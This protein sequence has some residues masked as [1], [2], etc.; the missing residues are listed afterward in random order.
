MA[1]RYVKD[2]EFPAAAGYTKSCETSPA[3]MAK[4]PMYAKGG[5]VAKPPAGKAPKGG[6]M[7]V[8]GVASP[9]KPPMKKAQGSYVDQDE[10]MKMLEERSPIQSG[11]YGKKKPAPP[12]KKEAPRDIEASDLYDEE[13][14]RRLER[15]YAKG[16]MTKS[17]KKIGKVMREYKAGELH[18]GKDG[19]VVKNPKQ[20]IAIA[21]SEA[22]KAKK[23]KG[24][25][26]QY[27]DKGKD[28]SVP[29]KDIK[30][31]KVKQSRD[32]DYY[33][34]VERSKKMP[35][36][37]R[38]GQFEDDDDADH[39]KSMYPSGGNQGRY[40]VPSDAANAKMSEA[41]RAAMY[42]RQKQDYERVE[43]QKE[44]DKKNARGSA[45]SRAQDR[46]DVAKK[47]ADYA[48]KEAEPYKNYPEYKKGGAAKHPDE[49]MDKELIRKMVKPE[50]RKKAFADGGP[51]LATSLPADPRLAERMNRMAA[52][53]NNPAGP[54]S[55]PDRD[56]YGD[57]MLFPP[58]TGGPLPPANPLNPVTGRPGRGGSPIQGGTM[59]P[60][61]GMGG[62]GNIRPLPPS[63]GP[64]PGAPPK[65]PVVGG[66]GRM[67][68]KSGGGVKSPL[69]SMKIGAKAPSMERAKAVPVASRAPLIQSP[70]MEA[71]APAAAKMGVGVNESRPGKPNVGRIR[72]MMAKA[73][74]AAK[75]ENS[76][77]VMK[78]GGMTK[79][80]C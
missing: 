8:I 61:P 3:K 48:R 65:M 26:I 32:A 47:Q 35:A 80:K 77:A 59:G 19:P 45:F 57:D 21:L 22:G 33:R 12:K 72:A 74:S 1:V 79:G 41:A 73:A 58:T 16:G 49:A 78:R 50:A 38:G 24:G 43:F 39:L 34:E 9:K 75:P 46:A 52:R 36:M 56:G 67:A 42:N 66:P 53:G 70:S 11:S 31:G 44:F 55:P 13:Q 62:P 54:L 5:S 10:Y 20:A 6:L 68:M 37:K 60:R 14:L 51:V 71:P 28:T 69:Q 2:F 17:Q 15:G 64:R 76:P 63:A 29:V 30:S 4:Q 18:S 23:A 27:I 40:M 7:V 25:K